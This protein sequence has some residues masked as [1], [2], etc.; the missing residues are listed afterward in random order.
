MKESGV[1]EGGCSWGGEVGEEVLLEVGVVFAGLGLRS[2]I[3]AG[4]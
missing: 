4:R 3:S 2:F 1:A